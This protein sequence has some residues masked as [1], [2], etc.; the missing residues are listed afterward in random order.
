M[1]EKL[2]F[3]LQRVLTVHEGNTKK[4]NNGY[5]VFTYICEISTD[6]LGNRTKMVGGGIFRWV[7]TAQCI[8]VR[9]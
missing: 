5:V 9:V 1:P 6:Q 8:C 4:E 2:N 3:L 7:D